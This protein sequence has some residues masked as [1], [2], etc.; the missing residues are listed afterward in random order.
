[1]YKRLGNYKT[2]F[3]YIDL[4]NKSKIT[5]ENILLWIKDLKIPPA[6]NNVIISTNKNS[7]IL[8][9]GFD[10][11]GRKQCLY[12]PNFVLYRSKIK[13]E[14][15]LKS[16][17]LFYNIYNQ[18]KK[19]IMIS[20]SQNINKKEISIIL[21]LIIN[22]GFRIGNKKYERDNN[23]Y[24]TSTI[25]FKHLLFNGNNTLTIDFI[26]KKGVKNIGICSHNEIIRYLKEKNKIHKHDDYVFTNILSKN[27][28]DYLKKWGNNISSKDLRTWNA[29]YMFVNYVKE[30]IKQ[31]EKK[32]IKYAIEKVA[33]K[34]HNT[35][36]V[37]KKN[38][39]DP[40]IIQLFEDK[41]K[42]DIYIKG[43]TNI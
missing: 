43:Q 4:K 33:Q 1:M 10:S 6:Y 27:V 37:C 14:K 21:F 15:I 8:A 17:K 29:N 32:P 40:K 24:G 30:A 12:H 7:K 11:K 42:N 34:L 16:H 13:F 28:N 9:Y 5:D 18:I 36:S 22:C 23:S 3:Q 31:C 26:G 38:Y 35:V 41:L 2:G 25:K 19:D 39:L 20:E